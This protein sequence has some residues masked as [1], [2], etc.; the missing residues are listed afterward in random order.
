MIHRMRYDFFGKSFSWGPHISR[1]CVA[2]VHG[3]NAV[4]NCTQRIMDTRLAVQIE[5]GGFF[6]TLALAAG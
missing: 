3:L 5:T 6:V 4:W 1:I 2:F